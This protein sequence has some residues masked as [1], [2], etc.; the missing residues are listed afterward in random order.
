MSMC[1]EQSGMDI[2]EADVAQYWDSNADTWTEH[3]RR[4]WDTYREVFTNPAFLR[5]LGDVR[6][7]RVLDAGCGEGS[8][9]RLLAQ[10]GATIAGI[11][12]SPRMIGAARELESRN[13]LG[14]GFE[15]ASFCDLSLFADAAFDLVVSFMA[16]MDGPDFPRAAAEIC[17][18]LRPYGELMFSILHP[19]F[20][21]KGLGWIR[22]DDG[23]CVKTV[24]SDYFDSAPVVQHWRFS[25]GDAPKDAPMFA[26]PRFPLTLS[27][28]FN[29]LLDAGFRFVKVEEPRPSEGMCE[30]YPWLWRFRLHMA[31]FLFI[32]VKKDAR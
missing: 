9:T 29:V 27:Q 32:H 26:V 10:H 20:N 31:P 8:N 3:V 1:V 16:L 6:G 7:K 17:R 30:K 14:I 4:G 22:D 24:Q 5:F 25:K 12:I 28:Y 11:D 15:V 21:T 13:P 23:N 2:S 19:C 18:V